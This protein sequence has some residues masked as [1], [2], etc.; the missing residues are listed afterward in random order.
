LTATEPGLAA[1]W[2]F[3]DGTGRDVSGHGYD[4]EL[5]DGATVIDVSAVGRPAKP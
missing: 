5:V 2:D 1:A 4:G 3:E